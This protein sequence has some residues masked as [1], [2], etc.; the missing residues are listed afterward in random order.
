MV[1]N[2][3]DNRL[4]IYIG[5]DPK[6]AGAFA[7]AKHSARRHLIAPVP[8][9]GVVLADL[10]RQGL[11]TRPTQMQNGRLWDTISE[12]PMSTEFAISRFLVPHLSG[13]KGYALFTDSDVLFRRDLTAIFNE[14][15]GDKAVYVVKHQHAPPVGIKMDG[16]LQSPYARKNW[17]SVML[18]NCAHPANRRLTVELV[19]EVPGRDLHR[20][21]W[22]R[23]ED[24]GELSPKWNWLVGESAPLGDETPHVVH[25][26]NGIPTMRGYENCEYADEWR[27]A[28]YE[29]AR[30]PLA[31]MPAEASRLVQTKGH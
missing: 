25:F 6:E 22:L 23:D 17:S 18:F 7:V 27:A 8:I 20:F 29:W 9:Y 16:Q 28:L 31:L 10:Q 3:I 12:H 19:N 2:L 13:D 5:F 15:T 21:C 4:G 11:Y 26:T 1:N 30:P 24:I 14:V